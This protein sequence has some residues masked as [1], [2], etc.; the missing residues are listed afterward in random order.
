MSFLKDQNKQDKDLK[1]DAA[2]F[3]KEID[4]FQGFACIAFKKTTNDVVVFNN[5]GTYDLAIASTVL[6]S[7]FI[8][9]YG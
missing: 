6:Q 9:S 8:K 2:A 5:C 3:L 7:E 1:E 4:K